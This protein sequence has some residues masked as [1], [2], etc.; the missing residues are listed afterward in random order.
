MSV[1][2]KTVD[3]QLKAIQEREEKIKIEKSLLLKK[4]KQAAKEN[5]DYFL[6]KLGEIFLDGF[7]VEA[8]EDFMN[9]KNALLTSI[10]GSNLNDREKKKLSDLAESGIINFERPK[11]RF[12]KEQENNN[13]N[14]HYQADR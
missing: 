7:K 9:S 13:S 4:K 11:P 2:L 3:R 14:L 6:K 10:D 8:G 12:K 5:K 1:D